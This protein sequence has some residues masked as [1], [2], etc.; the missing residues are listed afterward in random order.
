MRK[1]LM[2]IPP[3]VGML[4]ATAAIAILAGC[5]G[6]LRQSPAVNDGPG[7]GTASS[8]HHRF[9]GTVVAPPFASKRA[10]DVFFHRPIVDRTKGQRIGSLRPCAAGYGYLF[11]SDNS[12]G[13]LDIY[14][15]PGPKYGVPFGEPAFRT[16]AGGAGWG[17]AV[18][19]KILAAG[20]TGGTITLYNLPTVAVNKTLTLAHAASGYNAY[21]L[22]FDKNGGLY[23]TE[24]PGP[25]VDY[26]RKP[27]AGGA[28]NCTYAA[29]LASEA[30][31]VAAVGTN[32]T[33]VY[34]FDGFSSSVPAVTE[35]VSNMPKCAGITEKPLLTLGSLAQGN[36]FPGGL[37][38]NKTGELIANNQY[39]TMY[40]LG[41]YPGAAV[42]A[43]CQWEFSPNDMTNLTFD[44]K[45]GI[46]GTD[47]NFAGSPLETYLW[48]FVYPFNG[49]PCQTPGPGGGPTFA[50]AS[51]EYLGVAAYDDG[52]GGPAPPPTEIFNQYDAIPPGPTPTN[53]EVVFAGDVRQYL[54]SE[55][56]WGPFNP[57]CPPSRGPNNP[58]P[59]SISYNSATNTTTVTYSGPQLY[60]NIPGHPGQA[61][62][63][64]LGS[65]A[66]Q[67]G[68]KVVASYWSYS[69][70]SSRRGTSSTVAMPA[71]SITYNQPL[72]DYGW[73]YAVVYV[74]ASFEPITASNPAPYGL[75][76]E[77]PYL[78]NGNNQPQFTFTNYG[79]Q[80]IYTA[81]SGI[82][83]NQPV[84]SDPK[85]QSNPACQENLT[86]LGNLNY[87]NMPPEDPGSPFGPMQYPP[88]NQ[89]NG[90]GGPGCIS[91]HGLG[92]S[93]CPV[94]LTASNPTQT[95]TVA[96][97]GGTVTEASNCGGIATLTE[98]SSG[99]T[100]KVTAGS[101]PGQ[102]VATFTTSGAG[103][104][105]EATLPITNQ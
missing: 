77:I 70:R 81:N 39:G 89:L 12:S 86:L 37:S 29:T 79:S 83:L 31:Y 60:Q 47:I 17:L 104:S 20:V 98:Q 44:T 100:W 92:V 2:R 84:P 13:N 45:R 54:G 102:C 5:A 34:G 105:I 68:L 80:P 18:F 61:H 21:G 76:F 63:G 28:P 51:D 73:A 4:G 24:W 25:Y 87:V 48:S 3:Q 62:F 50:V 26:W 27:T 95:V 35:M 55:P 30:Y 72:G 57:F 32:T 69:A 10:N 85:C 43:T 7:A 78:P 103:G 71:L 36:G 6:A 64:L 101:Q 8:L 96:S 52:P 23:A 9:G 91:S 42:K 56:L 99:Q 58:C 88:P 67:G 46:W 66:P 65:N 33:V 82:V 53:F 19:K 40:D 14:C 11:G 15:G 90:G 74:E 16:I 75:W 41:A 93:P 59:P 49:G 97:S 22:A 38:T 1:C 94:T